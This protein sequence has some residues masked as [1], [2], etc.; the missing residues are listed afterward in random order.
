AAPL[1][2]YLGDAVFYID[3]LFDRS[4]AGME[5]IGGI[6]KWSIPCNW[7]LAAEQFA[8]DMY[9]VGITHAG[10]ITAAMPDDIPAEE[11]KF[12]VNEGRQYRAV[13]GGHGSGFYLN[14]DKN[15]IIGSVLG[16]KVNRYYNE[17]LQKD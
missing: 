12:A 6:H 4:P 2:D 8:S 16:A 10:A 9:H 14:D 1:P 3:T 7:K 15:Y 13:A 11:R 5:V 17:N